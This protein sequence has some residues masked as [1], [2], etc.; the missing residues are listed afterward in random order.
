MLSIGFIH[1]EKPSYY[2]D[3]KQ[4][5]DIKTMRDNYLEWVKQYREEGYKIYYEDETWVFKN[6]TCSK[7]WSDT[8]DKSTTDV[9]KVPSGKGERSILSHVG[10]SETGLLDVCM[11]LF[12]RSKANSS[13]DYHS[14]MNWG[15]FS[16]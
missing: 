5:E 11:L 12:R 8:M 10:S 6:M 14:E 9:F 3:T 4:R 1:G 2:K 7:V 16:D 15:G 13:S